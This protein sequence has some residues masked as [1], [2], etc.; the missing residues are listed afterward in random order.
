MAN[1]FRMGLV[2]HKAPLLGFTSFLDL[3][4]PNPGLSWRTGLKCLPTCCAFSRC[5]ADTLR[6]TIRRLIRLWVKEGRNAPVSKGLTVDS[7]NQQGP[8][9]KLLDNPNQ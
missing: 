6:T 3:D 9:Q 8:S 2:T 1:L 5:C 7:A 4:S